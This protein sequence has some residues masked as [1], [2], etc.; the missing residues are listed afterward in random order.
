MR[1]AALIS[2][3]LMQTEFE[4][5]LLLD[6]CASLSLSLSLFYQGLIHR[7]VGSFALYRLIK[8]LYIISCHYFVFKMPTYPL[9]HN[10]GVVF[11]G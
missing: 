1:T 5:E 7:L 4:P 3:T 8:E 11:S 9:T 6:E 10:C 2:Y